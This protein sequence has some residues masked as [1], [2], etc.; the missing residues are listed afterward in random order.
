MR[1]RLARRKRNGVDADRPA[2]LGREPHATALLREAEPL[3]AAGSYP[4]NGFAET[5]LDISA[6]VDRA[7]RTRLA[8]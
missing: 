4:A 5:N 7:S 8:G 3:P 6:A 1:I 2:E